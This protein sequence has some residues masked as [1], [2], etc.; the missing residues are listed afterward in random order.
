M[1]SWEEGTV[2]PMK[3]TEDKGQR[4]KKKMLRVDSFFPR[5]VLAGSAF[6]AM[7]C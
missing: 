7:A 1:L 4:S 2:T 3:M 5:G 6:K